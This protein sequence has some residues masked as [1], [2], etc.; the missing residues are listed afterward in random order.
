MNSPTTFRLVKLFR[1]QSSESVKIF[2]CIYW[3]ESN[4]LSVSLDSLEDLT[5][6]QVVVHLEMLPPDDVDILCGDVRVLEQLVLQPSD[7]YSPTGFNDNDGTTLTLPVGISMNDLLSGS[8]EVTNELTSCPPDS[9]ESCSVAELPQMKRGKVRIPALKRPTPV[10]APT[11]CNPPE[12]T[13]QS[14]NGS[15]AGGKKI[16]S[17][18][19]ATYLLFEHWLS[20]V[21]ERINQTMHY[22]MSGNPEPLVYQ[23]PHSFFE[24]LRERISSGGQRKKRLPNSTTV[25]TRKDGPPYATQ[26]TKYS[27][28]L[29]NPVTVKHVFDTPLVNCPLCPR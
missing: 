7:D 10:K 22:Q 4:I 27:W 13:G 16:T 20:S 23:I 18:E 25:F 21:T 17:D 26:L 29:Q 14:N 2:H 1:K 5:Q 9:V 24:C 6:R 3:Q 12:A 28:H 8:L 15:A 11:A 19:Q